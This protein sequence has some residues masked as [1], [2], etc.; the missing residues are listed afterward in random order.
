MM[1][2]ARIALLRAPTWRPLA[3][4]GLMRQRRIMVA[5]SGSFS[6][7][8]PAAVVFPGQGAHKPGMG[9]DWFDAFA[10]SRA[11]FDE[12]SSALGYDVSRL[13]FEDAERLALTEYQ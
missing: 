9:R 5:H 7:E 3:R 13:C 12:A 4:A 1:R 8:R 6:G 2:G 10:E 11:V